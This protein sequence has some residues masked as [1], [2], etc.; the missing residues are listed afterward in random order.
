MDIIGVGTLNRSESR[1]GMGKIDAARFLFR[2][3]GKKG[4]EEP[5][6]QR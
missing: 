5:L 4:I 1:A 3:K 6:N 2:D